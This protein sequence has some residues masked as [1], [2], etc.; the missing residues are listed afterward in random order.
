MTDWRVKWQQALAELERERDELKLKIH[1]AK[2][3]GRDQL[4]RLDGKIAELRQHVQ[5]AGS[6]AKGAMGDVSGAAKVL[7]DEIK[8]GFDRVRKTL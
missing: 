1:L 3:D 2:A 6:E 5:A 8:A 7:I 4:A